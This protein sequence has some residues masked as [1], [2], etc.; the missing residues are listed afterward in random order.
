MEMRADF[1]RERGWIER[2]LR[3]NRER[4]REDIKLATEA[5][6]TESESDQGKH[7]E[8]E[9]EFGITLV[10]ARTRVTQRARFRSR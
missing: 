6:L 5:E 4:V 9:T 7:F 3:E 2:R 10:T 8:P 1:D